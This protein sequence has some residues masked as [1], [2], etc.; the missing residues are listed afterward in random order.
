M[1]FKNI[2]FRVPVLYATALLALK[3]AA[4]SATAKRRRDAPVFREKHGLAAAMDHAVDCR[5]TLHAWRTAYRGRGTA[6]L[7]NKRRAPKCQRTQPATG[8]A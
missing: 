4:M 1:Q 2:G 7:A 3:D 6:G 5:S 8:V